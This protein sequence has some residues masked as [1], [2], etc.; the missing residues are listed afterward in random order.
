MCM[1]AARTDNIVKTHDIPGPI[2][3]LIEYSYY[4]TYIVM[5]NTYIYVVDRILV[6]HK[7]CTYVHIPRSSGRQHLCSYIVPT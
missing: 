6:L 2:T 7:L 3:I 1:I 4:N 5:Y